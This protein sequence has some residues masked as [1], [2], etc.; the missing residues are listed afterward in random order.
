VREKATLVVKSGAG[1]VAAKVAT[2]MEQIG[3]NK[4]QTTT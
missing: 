4:T 1:L 3:H 2:T